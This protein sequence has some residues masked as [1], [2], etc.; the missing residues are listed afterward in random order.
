MMMMMMMM[1]KIIESLLPLLV[2]LLASLSGALPSA[3]PAAWAFSPS[4]RRAAPSGRHVHRPE[5]R[6][7]AATADRP[8]AQ[9]TAARLQ[10]SSGQD[11]AEN[12]GDA[13]ADSSSPPL[14]DTSAA[15]PEDGDWSG[16]NPFRQAASTTATSAAA[17]GI[18]TSGT[19]LSPRT[20]R[21]TSL[22]SELYQHSASPSR[23]DEL[24][25]AHA[26]FLVEQ[27]VDVDAVLEVGSVYE[28]DMDLDRRRD[29]YEAVMAERIGGAR[30]GEVRSVL[31][32]LRDFVLAEVDRR[33]G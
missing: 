17:A 30:S 8:G 5:E 20:V 7:C 23:M 6:R 19:P 28:A 18:A 11:S 31:R 16:F 26:D 9:S 2:L 15:P 14:F 27:L 32:A 24:L 22:T 33:R 13:D 25:S 12:N 21:M 1:V 3:S 29:V 10:A 4:H